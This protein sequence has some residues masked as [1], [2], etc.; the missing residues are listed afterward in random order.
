MVEKDIIQS[1]EKVSA[2]A[3]KRLW[4]DEQFSIEANTL[5]VDCLESLPKVSMDGK[6]SIAAHPLSPALQLP[7]GSSKAFG[8]GFTNRSVKRNEM[9][10][11]KFPLFK[12][13]FRA[14]QKESIDAF[15][16][17]FDERLALTI[18]REKT[19]CLKR[20]KKQHQLAFFR[21]MFSLCT[22]ASLPYVDDDSTKSAGLL[23]P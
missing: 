7:K 13:S 11:I 12:K 3:L 1:V 23:F 15:E 21:W 16:K 8:K 9:M 5:L 19:I 20:N 6:L 14:L 10:G 22:V 2:K 17:E 18:G 4:K